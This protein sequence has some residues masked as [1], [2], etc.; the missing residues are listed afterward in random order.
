MGAPV[1]NLQLTRLDD[2]RQELRIELDGDHAGNAL[3]W[4]GHLTI[5][6]LLDQIRPDRPVQY[7][8]AMQA[9]ADSDPEPFAVLE[10]RRPPSGEPEL[11]TPAWPLRPGR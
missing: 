5:E 7:E 2:G 3:T 6:P 1:K 9:H 4:R 8:L 10:F 11:F